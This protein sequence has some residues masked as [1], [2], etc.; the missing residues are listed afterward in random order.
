MSCKKVNRIEHGG[1][2]Y[3]TFQRFCQQP[4]HNLHNRRR[5]LKHGGSMEARK[6][7]DARA[8]YGV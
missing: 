2:N 3:T 4:T 5:V 8:A 6:T 7:L 1:K